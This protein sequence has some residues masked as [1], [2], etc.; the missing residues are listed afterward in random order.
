MI[1]NSR[2]LACYRN[3]GELY[4]FFWPDI[5]YGQH[6]GTFW[7]GLN[8]KD[9]DC[10]N[11]TAWFH[12]KNGLVFQRYLEDTNILET[13][14]MNIQRKLNVL[15]ADFVLPDRDVL[16]RRY[17]IVNL[18]ANTLH[19][20]FFVYCAPLLEESP[21]YDSAY[22]DPTNNSL[23]FFRRNVYLTLAASGYNISGFQCG[24]RDTPSDPLVEASG[25]RLWGIQDNIMLSS[26]SL[27][28][29]MGELGPGL[30]ADI[31]IYFIAGRS[32]EKNRRQ[33][34][35]LLAANPAEWKDQTARHWRGYL[36]KAG[37]LQGEES[38]RA[39][40]RRSLLTLQLMTNSKTGAS[41]AA[42]EFDPF[43]RAC[44]GYGYCWG[45]DATFVAAAFDEA[46]YHPQAEK[47]YHFAARVQS[48]D[49]SWRQRYFT[50]GL[51][52]PTWG[53]QVDQTGTILWGYYHH[54][55]LTGSSK[56]L[57]G[58]W[59]SLTAGASYLA[60]SLAENGLPAPGMDLWEDEFSQNTYSS[61]ASCGGLTA[62]AEMAGLAGEN[63]KAGLW[64]Q[65]AKKIS[66]GILKYQWSE[67]H[68]RFMRGVN[69]RV[70][71]ESYEQALAA[72]EGTSCC[73]DRTGIYPDYR[74]ARDT[75]IDAALLGLVFPFAVFKPGDQ[76]MESTVR[77][78]EAE[79][80]N[81]A[82]GGLSRYS[83]DGY[84]GGN[85]WLIT[86]FWLSIYYSAL[87]KKERARELCQ[88]CLKQSNQLL[89]LPE[90]A[91]RAGG[92]PAWAMPLSWSHAMQ[93]LSTLAL[94]DKLSIL[95]DNMRK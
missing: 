60:G 19:P 15:Q 74:V 13:T 62:A 57:A 91:N 30:S 73:T 21:L 93:I 63:E 25:G 75:R 24:R 61:A 11:R 70:S 95:R 66:E 65:A 94:T 10:D 2:I 41:I 49:G 77:A 45:R 59:P 28:W 43:Y 50:K 54:F 88:W 29:D 32:R 82:A 34:A 6:L 64:R 27:S 36:A 51:A 86:T 76:R 33:L 48:P 5:D 72:G 37:S 26:G 56:F 39:Y 1:G 68:N 85:P 92:G 17:Q 22:F 78:I 52:A 81:S 20:H 80:W 55:R 9:P 90:Q 12:L 58:I 4:R 84:R 47:F 53:K 40:Y 38:Q 89:L 35:G 18:S 23:V 44:G 83:G 46:G 31:A 42:P 79:L 14:Y 16:V 69:R 67:E 87:G 8:L 7:C 3:T 71:R